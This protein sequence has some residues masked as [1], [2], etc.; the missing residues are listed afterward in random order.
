[1]LGSEIV[2]TIVGNKIDLIKNRNVPLETAEQYAQSVGAKHY[3]TSAKL[4][5]GIEELFLEL[6]NQ[7]SRNEKKMKN[8]FKLILMCVFVVDD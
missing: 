8:A 5:D 7:V 1:M 2:L 6:T 4:N 3:E